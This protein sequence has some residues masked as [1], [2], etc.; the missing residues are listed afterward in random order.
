LINGRGSAH[1][2]YINKDDIRCIFEGVTFDVTSGKTS[3]PVYNIPILTEHYTNING[4]R[5]L[6]EG[7]WDYHFDFVSLAEKIN[8][9]NDKIRT[10]RDALFSTGS[11]KQAYIAVMSR[12]QVAFNRF[13]AKATEFANRMVMASYLKGV[14]QQRYPLSSLGDLS[15]IYLTKVIFDLYKPLDRF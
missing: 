13:Y 9:L 5:M 3:N 12:Y 14:Y 6:V 1:D 8:E 2:G 7:L 4:E 11:R 15:H 10:F